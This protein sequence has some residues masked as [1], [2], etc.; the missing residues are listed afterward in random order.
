MNAPVPC[1]KFTVQ[2]TTTR[3]LQKSK[4]EFVGIAPM[5]RVKKT[6]DWIR[7]AQEVLSREKRS[8]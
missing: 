4:Y 8:L 2:S 1:G 3:Y 7:F 6:D 5:F